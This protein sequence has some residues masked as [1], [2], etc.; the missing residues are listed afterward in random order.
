MTGPVLFA[1]ELE[2]YFTSYATALATYLRPF[3]GQLKRYWLEIDKYRRSV[4]VRTSPTGSQVLVLDKS[5]RAPAVVKHTLDDLRS[6]AGPFRDV[7]EPPG[8]SSLFQFRVKYFGGL[9]AVAI[10]MLEHHQL[11][12]ELQSPG[13]A[14]CFGFEYRNGVPPEPK[15]GVART[16]EESDRIRAGLHIATPP[17][18]AVM[19]SSESDP[20]RFL[21]PDPIIAAYGLAESF[22]VAAGV[23]DEEPSVR[24]GQAA[25]D[26]EAAV[27]QLS[28]HNERELQNLLERRPWIL[29]DESDYVSVRFRPSFVV[30]ERLID[31]TTKD[32]E[33][34]PDA[35][36]EQHDSTSLVV[37]IESAAKRLLVTRTEAS[38]HVPAA[39]LTASSTQIQGYRR[40]FSGATGSQLRQQLGK[41]DSWSFHYRLV[42]GLRASPSF[43]ERSWLALRDQLDDSKIEVRTWDYYIDRLRRLAAA[44]AKAVTMPSGQ[45]APDGGN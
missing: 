16:S 5:L 19:L 26:L 13:T 3:R 6:V 44:S 21:D 39:P 36:Y 30:H 40:A 25:S 33:I 11:A 41:P 38:L 27:A 23:R 45:V 2:E 14:L 43:D 42:I 32:Y 22:L 29:V 12:I 17:W 1:Q 28:Q 18:V 9:A 4:L 8:T 37:E 20:R 34:V 15:G 31:G 35:V 7:Q 24:F 10:R